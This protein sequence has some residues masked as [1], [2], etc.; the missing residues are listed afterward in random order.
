MLFHPLTVKSPFTTMVLGVL[1]DIPAKGPGAASDTLV[2][3][4]VAS[5]ICPRSCTTLFRPVTS[6]RFAVIT[7]AMSFTLGWGSG[8][9]GGGFSPREVPGGAETMGGRFVP[10]RSAIVV[11][12]SPVSG[13]PP[14]LHDP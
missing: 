6:S 4:L 8:G 11:Y 13:V 12:P 7:V 1:G 2:V 9:G 14:G 10:E 5:A 3:P